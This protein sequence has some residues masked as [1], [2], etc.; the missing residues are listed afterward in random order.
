MQPAV[1]VNEFRKQVLEY[2]NENKVFR[3]TQ[4][5]KLTKRS[6]YTVRKQLTSMAKDGLIKSLVYQPSE[7][8]SKSESCIYGTS[9]D[10]IQ[11]YLSKRSL[12]KAK[13]TIYQ[14]IRKHD[15]ISLKEIESTTGS[16]HS[17]VI[18]ALRSLKTDG[19]I[20]YQYT[21]KLY[22]DD[23]NE[24]VSQSFI[25]GHIGHEPVG[26]TDFRRRFVKQMIKL[27]DEQ[28]NREMSLIQITKKLDLTRSTA[29]RRMGWVIDMGYC[30]KILRDEVVSGQS[31]QVAT[32]KR[33]NPL[34]FL[35]NGERTNS[36]AKLIL[37]PDNVAN[38]GER[39]AVC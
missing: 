21:N 26:T 33:V 38:Q 34:S 2:A 37:R 36:I 11:K 17:M 25:Q 18:R 22:F 28:P 35:S 14:L 15:G 16:A 31:R 20:K 13:D 29:D 9:I 1:D 7:D 6:V 5:L 32:F 19:W 24:G 10:A 3:T 30:V 4:I 8:K 12:P 23:Y 27:L 39:H